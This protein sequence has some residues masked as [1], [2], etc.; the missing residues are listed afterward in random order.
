MPVRHYPGNLMPPSSSI[1][2][3]EVLHQA[4]RANRTLHSNDRATCYVRGVTGKLKELSEP[5]DPERG[6]RTASFRIH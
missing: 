4:L 1:D 5:N 3:Q 2:F 6:V